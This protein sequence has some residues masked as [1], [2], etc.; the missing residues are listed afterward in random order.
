MKNVYKKFV[1]VAG[2]LIFGLLI[3]SWGYRGHEK[4]AEKSGQSYNGRMKPFK[5]WMPYLIEHSPDPDR[6]KKLDKTEAP[7]HYI[8]LDSFPEYLI[9]GSVP[10]KIDTLIARHGETFVY[11]QGVLPWA[12][13]ITYDSLVNCFARFDTVK[14]KLFAADL[15]HYVADGH[16]PLHL[17]SNYNGQNTGNKGIHG[18]YESDMVN[19]YLDSIEF[20]PTKLKRIRNVEDYVFQYIYNCT[21]Y[22][23]SIL[24]ADNKAKAIAPDC[25]SS[26]Y[27]DVL[28]ANT[29]GFTVELFSQAS[30]DYAELLYNAWREAGRPR[31][32]PQ[33]TK[34]NVKTKQQVNQ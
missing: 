10:Q 33:K 30:H 21:P 28:W 18:R 5:T 9:T 12:T 17:T 16:M 32:T 15:C 19:C 26:A 25:E 29:K 2:L 3:S 1:W 11:E 4:I 20:R 31:I 7:K 8:D 13:L 34:Q 27:Q 23:D 24:I 22:I 14:T 6:R